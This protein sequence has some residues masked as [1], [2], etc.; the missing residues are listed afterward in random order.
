MTDGGVH[1]G[2]YFIKSFGGGQTEP[3]YFD[4]FYHLDPLYL[5][6]CLGQSA[7]NS[8]SPALLMPFFDGAFQPSKNAV[9][10]EGEGAETTEGHRSC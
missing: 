8:I 2:Y 3:L 6:P 5:Q 10:T 7:Q 4:C 9:V 1:T